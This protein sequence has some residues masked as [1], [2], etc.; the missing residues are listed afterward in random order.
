[1][2]QADFG[3]THGCRRITVDGTEVALAVYQY[4]AHGK[5]LR[6][7]NDRIVDRRITVRVIFTDDIAHYAGRFLVRPVPVVGQLLH[8]VEHPAMYRSQTVP[9]IGQ[10]APDDH[11]HGIIEIRLAH[12]VFKVDRQDLF[13]DVSHRF[14]G[15]DE[16]ILARLQAAASG[17]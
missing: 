8:G 14:F 10:S 11:A 9:D 2:G 15:I 7:A 3:V 17:S 12:L 5:I 16:P 1:L 6:H 4:I 13:S